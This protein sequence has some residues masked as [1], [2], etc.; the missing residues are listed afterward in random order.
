MRTNPLARLYDTC[1]S[2][3]KFFFFNRIK[4][5]LARYKLSLINSEG[6]LWTR[7]TSQDYTFSELTILDKLG[8]YFD[9]SKSTKTLRENTIMYTSQLSDKQG[10]IKK[11]SMLKRERDNSTKGRLSLWYYNLRA[12]W[13]HPTT[14]SLPPSQ[15]RYT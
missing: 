2:Q 1:H 5:S 4:K 3:K 14:H 9:Y 11:Y 10:N 15:N 6:L 12:R 13:S 7:S 8:P